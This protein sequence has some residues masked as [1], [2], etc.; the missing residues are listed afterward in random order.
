MELG[1]AWP[2]F[3]AHFTGYGFF[4]FWKCRGQTEGNRH[5][6]LLVF[7]IFSLV[8]LFKIFLNTH[9]YH[10]GFALALPATL[11]LIKWT[12]YDFPRWTQ[13]YLGSP[14]F[15]RVMAMTLILTFIGGNAWF[16]FKIYDLKGYPVGTGLD[17]VA[18]YRT[19]FTNRGQIFNA[20]LE[21][22]NRHLEPEAEFVTLPDAIMLNYMPGAKARLNM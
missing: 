7:A 22:I 5:L 21:Y 14:V 4:R 2:L 12:A 11:L 13:R 20:T 18:D 1:R 3:M 15:T 8:L 16:S 17:T 19:P 9:V 10:Y 6:A